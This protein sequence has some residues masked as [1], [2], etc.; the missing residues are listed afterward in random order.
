[1]DLPNLEKP[2]TYEFR[3]QTGIVD[4]DLAISFLIQ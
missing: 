2:V 1:M 4:S 3:F